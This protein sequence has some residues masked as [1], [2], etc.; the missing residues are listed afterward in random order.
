MSTVRVNLI[1]TNHEDEVLVK[2]GHLKPEQVRWLEAKDVL[3]DTGATHLA[4]HKSTING[5]GL[6][7]I[8]EIQIST[9][10]GKVPTGVYDDIT[11]T[12][13]G[14]SATF[15]CFEIRDENPEIM[16]VTVM[17]ILGLRPNLVTEKLDLLKADDP[18]PDGYMFIY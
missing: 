9:A 15:Q 13:R 14:R 1:L 3:V 11:V 17:E 10:G 5:L 4:L 7:K 8:N 6:R 12:F 16:G 2:R 18:Y